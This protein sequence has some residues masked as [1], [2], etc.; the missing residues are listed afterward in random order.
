MGLNL[1]LNTDIDFLRAFKFVLL[2]LYR[3]VK[4]KFVNVS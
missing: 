2:D 4:I 1:L 3:S